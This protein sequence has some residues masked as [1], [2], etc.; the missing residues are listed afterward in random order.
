M[1]M[2]DA[3]TTCT[4]HAFQ[5]HKRVVRHIIRLLAPQ[6]PSLFAYTQHTGDAVDDVPDMVQRDGPAMHGI[7]AQEAQIIRSFFSAKLP[8]A[9]QQDP[10]LAGHGQEPYDQAVCNEFAARTL[11]CDDVR[12]AEN[13]GF[14]SYAVQSPSRQKTMTLRVRPFDVATTDFAHGIYGARVPK[15]YLCKVYCCQH[16]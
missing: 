3:T 11:K 15:A 9:I 7:S 5:W 10:S 2:M 12:P 13:Q 6:T 14:S 16:M 4:W 8:P 1:A